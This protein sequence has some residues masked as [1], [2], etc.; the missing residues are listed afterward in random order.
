MRRATVLWFT[1]LSGSGK[2]T[3]AANLKERLAAQG[4]EVLTLDGDDVRKTLHQH[5]GFSPD[6]I[7]LNNQLIAELC[8]S[9]R[10]EADYIL[11]PVIAPFAEVREQVR[12]KL[13]PGFIEVFVDT[14]LEECIKRDVKGLYKKALAGEIENFIGISDNV[15]YQRPRDAEVV[16]ETKEQTVEQSIEGILNYLART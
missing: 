9:R 1:G 10:T 14:S 3:I 7:K 4:K 5:L 2:S 16:L 6:D 13:S 8:S 12:K 11:V 15:P